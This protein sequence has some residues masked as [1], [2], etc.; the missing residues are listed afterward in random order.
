MRYEDAKRIHD[1]TPN[2]FYYLVGLLKGNK[3]LRLKLL[4]NLQSLRD[5][6]LMTNDIPDGDSLKFIMDENVE[7]TKLPIEE[8][9]EKYYSLFPTGVRSGGYPVKDGL[10]NVIKKMTS[11][12]REYPDYTDE[13]ILNTVEKYVLDKKK[14]GYAFMKLAS[15]LIYKDRVSSLVGLIEEYKEKGGREETTKWGRT[16]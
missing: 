4:C 7:I 10:S 14:E 12:R 3:D 15:H 11:F 9:C 13:D 1:I 6:G 16:V 8:F 5:K 2:E